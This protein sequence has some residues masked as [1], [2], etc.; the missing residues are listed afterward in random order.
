MVE[1]SATESSTLPILRNVLIEAID[2]RI[3]LT[4]TNL[5]IATTSWVAGKVIEPGRITVPINLLS[6]VLAN[7]SS[8]RLNLETKENVLEIKTDNYTAIL[9]GLSADDYPIIPPVK[10]ETLTLEMKSSVLRESLSQVIASSQMNDLRPELSSILL[11]FNLEQLEF[12]ATDGFRLADKTVTSGQFKANSDD[13][14][15]M[16]MPLRSA[17][18]LSRIL[19][20]D[21]DV[22]IIYD[23]NQVLFQT[24]QLR[25]ISRLV[26]GNYPD[27]TA[28]I[29]RGFDTEL[30]LDRNELMN[31]LKLAGV[32]STRV[33][34]I[35]LKIHVDRKVVEVFSTDQAGENSYLISA[36]I[37]G[38]GREISFNWKFLL[39][40]L[41][42][43]SSDEVFWGINEENKPALLKSPNDGSYFYILMP[44][45]KA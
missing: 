39:D 44:I 18:E 11:N 27:Y 13:S 32:F 8:E 45:L 28:I 5:E 26:E 1:R 14:F 41:R 24:E 36:K 21:H 3:Q 35:R 10:S 12:V 25:F 40:G 6:G 34:E 38:V 23:N 31:A 2:G 30:L 22:R 42:A 17:Q 37:K 29:P 16:L 4:A 20:D 43:L 15:R 33:N 7:L 19:R 9:Q